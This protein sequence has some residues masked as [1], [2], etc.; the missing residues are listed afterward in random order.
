MAPAV[1]GRSEY[2]AVLV[3]A[4][5][6]SLAAAIRLT[7]AGLRPV[8]VEKSATVGGATAYS[9]G[10]VWAPGN[11]RMRAKGIE[12]SATE[13]MTYLESVARGRW[14][15]ELASAYVD[16]IGWILEWLEEVSPLRWMVY[17]D[18]PD[19]FAERPG[20]KLAGRCVLP[21]PRAIAA[22]LDAAAARQPELGLVRDSVHFPAERDGWA[23]GRALVGSLWSRVLELEVDYLMETRAVGL[24]REGAAIRGVEVDGPEGRLTLRA[25]AGVLLNTGGFEWNRTMTSQCVPGGHL[26][27]PQTPPIGDGDGHVMAAKVGAALAL[28]DQTIS[29]PSIRVPDEDNEGHPLYRLLFQELS[30]PHSLIVN[31][32]GERFA[33]ETFFQDIVRGWDEYDDVAG[34]NPNLPMYFIFDSEYRRSYGTPDGLEVGEYLTEHPD[35]ASLA[36]T[37]GIDLEGLEAQVG[38]LNADARCGVDAE[39]ARGA[40]AYQRAFAGSPDAAENPTIGAVESAPFYCLELFAGTSGHRGGAV[41]DRVGRVLD[42]EG[43]PIAGLYA[44]G[45]VAAGLVTGATYLTGASVGQA[46]VFAVLAADAMPEDALELPLADGELGQRP[47]SRPTISNY[48]ETAG[49]TRWEEGEEI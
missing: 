45:S 36:S 27:N 49:N 24:M 7:E 40:T 3:G 10:V 39:F 23:A 15:R 42:P 16:G 6:G 9:G 18:L 32:A 28:M 5:I 30:Y 12:D 35:L 33:N 4:G 20:G 1:L 44:C 14:D 8:V 21:Q 41:I 25:R 37:H 22:A 17:P 47:L 19:Y 38:R 48:V 29:T 26:V 13:A 11:H 46:L 43:C 34:A 2:D 31:S